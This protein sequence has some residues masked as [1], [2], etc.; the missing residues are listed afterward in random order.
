[1]AQHILACCF[2]A[3]DDSLN[4]PRLSKLYLLS[5]MLDGVQ[6]NLVVF[7]AQQLYCA[8]VSTKG[9]IV[10]GGVITTIARFFGIKLNPEDRFS[11]SERLQQALLS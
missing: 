6:I 11:A 1:V 4:V 10:I 5:C 7:L 9:R 3:R 8:V 2:F